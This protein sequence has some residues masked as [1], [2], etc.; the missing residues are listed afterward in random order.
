VPESSKTKN[1]RIR[2]PIGFKLVSII[3]VLLLLSL[4]AITILVSF[5][6]SRD[7]RLTAEDTNLTVNTRSAAEAETILAFTRANVLMFL[8][9]LELAPAR[10]GQT[11]DFFFQENRDIAAVVWESGTP[12]ISDSFFLS[13]EAD[14]DLIASFLSAHAGA[15][16]KASPRGA[17]CPK[18][19]PTAK[20]L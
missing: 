5:M 4:G 11:A 9:A 13:N 12:L 3:T 17:D 7:V 16:D 10:S 20:K 19:P 6:V 2:F 8:H 18:T 1:S 15:F 14:S